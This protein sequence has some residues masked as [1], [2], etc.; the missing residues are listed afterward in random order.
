MLD[1]STIELK[2]TPK[3]G[4]GV[5]STIYEERA[6]VCAGIAYCVLRACRTFDLPRVALNFGYVY[7]YE[8][9]YTVVRPKM[10]C[11]NRGTYGFGGPSL[12]LIVMPLCNSMILREADAAGIVCLFFARHFSRLQSR[13]IEGN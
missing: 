4:V 8:K 5:R 6:A 11:R 13:R 1:G 3:L 7:Y 2:T 10:V 9:T 12:A